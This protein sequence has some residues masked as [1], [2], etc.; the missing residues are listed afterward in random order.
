MTGLLEASR[1][2]ISVGLERAIVE[3]ARAEGVELDQLKPVRVGSDTV[4]EDVE[5]A[6][7]VLGRAVERW[8]EVAPSWKR[9]NFAM[10]HQRQ[11]FW[12]W[13]ATSVSVSVYYDP[14]ADWTQCAMVNAEKELTTCCEDGATRACDAPNKLSTPLRRADVLDRMHEGAV[15]Y[16]VIR[17]EIDAGRPVGVR[18]EWG[19]TDTGHFIVIEGYQSS[20]EEG[21]AVEDPQ[22]GPSDVDFT[23]L[24]KGFYN[25]DGAWTHTYFTRPQRVRPLARDEIRLASEIWERVRA[26]D[27]LVEERVR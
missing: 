10:Q 3:T 25:G 17:R 12:C 24:T 14:R 19:D 27:S 22:K 4:L 23:T 1:V 8:R 15:D 2:P 7:R 16:D 18:V 9:L 21:L 20:G 26:E 13:A 11:D 5:T 6:R